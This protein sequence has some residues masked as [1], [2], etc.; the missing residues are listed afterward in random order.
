MSTILMYVGR[1]EDAEANLIKGILNNP[2][3]YRGHYNLFA[4]YCKTKKWDKA[5]K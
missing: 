3:D 4:I 5:L 1:P 2:Y